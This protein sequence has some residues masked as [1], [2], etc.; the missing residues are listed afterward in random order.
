VF[1]PE[2]TGLLLQQT[3]KRPG[4]EPIGRLPSDAQM[5]NWQRSVYGWFFVES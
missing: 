3:Q 1:L 2:E 5:F 4:D